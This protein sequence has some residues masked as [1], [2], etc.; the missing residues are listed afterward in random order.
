MLT[1]LTSAHQSSG[2][3][4]Q[5]NQ[6]DLRL[7]PSSLIAAMSCVHS[8][9]RL[10]RH[11]LNKQRAREV[12]AAHPVHKGAGQACALLA[13]LLTRYAVLL[14][15]RGA[16]SCHTLITFST[17]GNAQVRHKFPCL[18][19]AE[20]VQKGCARQGDLKLSSNAHVLHMLRLQHLENAINAPVQALAGGADAVLR[21]PR[22]ARCPGS[23]SLQTSWR[24]GKSV[25]QAQWLWIPGWGLQRQHGHL[26]VPAGHRGLVEGEAMQIGHANWLS[27]CR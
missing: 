4:M 5:P 26:L 2:H 18:P 15:L 23:P 10:V 3:M 21:C 1:Q 22:Q 19:K 25:W 7:M 13:A 11:L 27:P 16:L 8:T 6:P 24:L 14:W 17:L 9:V 12:L 20:H